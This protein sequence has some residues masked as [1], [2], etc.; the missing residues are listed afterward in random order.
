MYLP[1]HILLFLDDV[2][3]TLES[4]Q[5]DNSGETQELYLLWRHLKC[6]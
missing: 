5:L 6:Q 2:L 4:L 3:K 1:A